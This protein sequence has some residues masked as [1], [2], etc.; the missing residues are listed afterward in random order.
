MSHEIA[1]ANK[2]LVLEAFDTLFN[3]RNC[4]AEKKVWSAQTRKKP[5][6]IVRLLNPGRL[7]G[8]SKPPEFTARYP[9]ELSWLC[10]TR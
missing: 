7:L 8:P 5:T 1:E 6:R 4:E 2:R 3:K 10:R 9:R